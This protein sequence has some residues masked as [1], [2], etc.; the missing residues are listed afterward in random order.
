M[1]TPDPTSGLGRDPVPVIV[2]AQDRE[3][4]E[5]LAADYGLDADDPFIYPVYS[6][7][8]VASLSLPADT[9]WCNDRGDARAVKA[10]IALYGNSQ[11]IHGALAVQH[12]GKAIP[13]R[14]L[15]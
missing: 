10:M 7:A 9:P 3:T 12:A 11:T 1:T 15:T 2:L 4:W 14:L 8:D 5:R 13:P 6:E